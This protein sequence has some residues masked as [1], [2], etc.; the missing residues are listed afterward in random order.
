M[1]RSYCL[2]TKARNL[3]TPFLVELRLKS[4]VWHGFERINHFEPYV[5]WLPKDACRV[6]VSMMANRRIFGLYNYVVKIAFEEKLVASKDALDGGRLAHDAAVEAIICKEAGDMATR[7]R[8]T[9]ASEMEYTVLYSKAKEMRERRWEEEGHMKFSLVEDIH[10]TLA[11][12]NIVSRQ[13]SMSKNKR[14]QISL[15]S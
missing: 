13:M 1:T 9:R 10:R 7:R 5:V 2:I 14:K 8:R 15:I 12:F 6:I 4:R 11:E 3:K